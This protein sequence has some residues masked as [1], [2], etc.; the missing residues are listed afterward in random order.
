MDRAE[1]LESAKAA[2]TGKREQDHGD[3]ENS[4]E[5]IAGFWSVYLG[6]EITGKDV[7]IMMTLL[8]IARIKTGHDER[9]SYIDSCGYMACAGELDSIFDEPVNQKE[10]F[11]GFLETVKKAY[12]DLGEE[13]SKL[14]QFY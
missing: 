14:K 9:D 10:L 2:I 13:L 6:E 11:K 5:T 7:A 1:V 3:M 4:F 12:Q 8:K